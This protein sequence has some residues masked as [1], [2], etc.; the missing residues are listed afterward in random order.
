[1][2]KNPTNLCAGGPSI[3]MLIHRIC[4]AFSGFGNF[5]NVEIVIKDSA[6]MLLK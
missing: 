5:I 3:I 1:M 6:A 2:N 4:I